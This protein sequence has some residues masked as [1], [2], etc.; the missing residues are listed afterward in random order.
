LARLT[1]ARLPV[2]ARVGA[3]DRED[4]ERGEMWV[5]DPVGRNQ[6]DI[7]LEI[8]PRVEKPPGG[9]QGACPQFE[10]AQGGGGQ[11]VAGS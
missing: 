6:G 1:V 4:G 5:N 3:V 9:G 11:K 8:A 10:G 2:A 7:D